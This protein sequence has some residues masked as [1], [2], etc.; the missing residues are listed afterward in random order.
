MKSLSLLIFIFSICIGTAAEN[1]SNRIAVVVNK[2]LK[3]KITDSL[4]IFLEDL[5]NENYEPI[6]KDWSLE[7]QPGP[8]SLK[9]YLDSL[10]REPQSLQGAIFIGDLPIA[11]VEDVMGEMTKNGMQYEAPFPSD[12]FYMDLNQLWEDTDGNGYFDSPTFTAENLAQTAIWVSRL[13]AS[14]IHNSSENLQREMQGHSEEVS[15]IKK[16]LQKNHAFR[17]G[18]K[19]YNERNWNYIVDELNDTVHGPRYTL[20][21]ASFNKNTDFFIG[22]LSKNLF[23]ELLGNQSNELGMWI[24]HGGTNAIWIN[25]SPE[26][27]Y[28]E[29]FFKLNFGTAFLLPQSCFIG[30]Y[31]VNNFIA[32]V[33]L[34]SEK[35]NLLTTVASARP[36]RIWFRNFFNYPFAEGENFGKSY[37]QFLK[38]KYYYIS[39]PQEEISHIIIGDGTLRRQ[40]YILPEFQP[41]P[42]N[43]LLR[44]LKLRRYI[45]PSSI[46]PKINT[47]RFNFSNNTIYWDKY[48]TN[49]DNLQY[50]LYKVGPKDNSIIYQGQETFASDDQLKKGNIYELTYV[51]NGTESLAALESSDYSDMAVETLKEFDPNLVNF[52]LKT[53]ENQ[54][55]ISA[56]KKEDLQIELQEK[57]IT[58]IYQQSMD[59]IAE[60][61]VEGADPNRAR[62]DG[63]TPLLEAINANSVEI[64]HFLLNT[65]ADPNLKGNYGREPI[66]AAIIRGSPEVVKSLIDYGVNVD[67]MSKGS[68]WFMTHNGEWIEID[69]RKNKWLPLDVAIN[70]MDNTP[71]NMQILDL[72]IDAGAKFYEEIYP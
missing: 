58:A 68:Q 63:Q 11:L 32:G 20:P 47:L 37:L 65:G 42:D 33:M 22:D 61:F 2:Y 16:Y 18:K 8:Q 38:A 31:T 9:T 39:G 52:I 6:L 66:T 36:S 50:R 26:I 21:Y 44:S 14:R 53:R 41:P 28:S 29:E 45:T 70:T 1:E 5:R 34:F 48:Y 27:I 24:F 40:R 69:F 55:E 64:I 59:R 17:T 25:G 19:L 12:H 15:F 56:S 60:L 30:N 54:A 43:D 13:P 10:Y 57:L 62:R 67:V 4:Q 72:L 7:E 35:S 3:P 71:D 49:K 23:L 51:W 46:V